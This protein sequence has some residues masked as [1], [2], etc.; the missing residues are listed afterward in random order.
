MYAQ[1]VFATYE[2]N[3][4]CPFTLYN[5]ITAI[6]PTRFLHSKADHQVLQL[7]LINRMP[8]VWNSILYNIVKYKMSEPVNKLLSTYCNKQEHNAEPNKRIMNVL[9]LSGLSRHIQCEVWDS[10]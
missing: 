3:F 5:I 4:H 7:N 9:I 1:S 8:Q 6:H 10:N 2:I